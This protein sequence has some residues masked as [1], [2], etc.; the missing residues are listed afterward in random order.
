MIRPMAEPEAT[1]RYQRSPHVV[2]RATLTAVVVL[3]VDGPEPLVL[4]GTGADVWTLLAEPRSL[5]ELVAAMVERYSGHAAVISADV[6][7]L[8]ATLRDAGVVLVTA[9]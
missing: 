5:A 2:W 8:L 6:S 1:V 9:T 4:A 7:A 3:A